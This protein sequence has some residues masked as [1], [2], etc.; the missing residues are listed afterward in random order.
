MVGLNRVF[1]WCDVLTEYLIHTQQ[2]TIAATEGARMAPS[3][4]FRGTIMAYRDEEQAIGA[5]VEQMLLYQLHPE[6]LR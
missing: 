3:V 2:K 5:V 1:F 6:N 4:F